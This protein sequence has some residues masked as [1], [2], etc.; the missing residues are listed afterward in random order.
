MINHWVLG[1]LGTQ[2]S[3]LR[4]SW[5]DDLSNPFSACVPC[6]FSMS[7]F[8]SWNKITSPSMTLQPAG[9]AGW[10]TCWGSVC[11]SSLPS[12]LWA[13]R[14]RHVFLHPFDLI[15]PWATLSR[16]FFEQSL[17]WGFCLMNTYSFISVFSET[18][19]L[20]RE[21][22]RRLDEQCYCTGTCVGQSPRVQ[23]TMARAQRR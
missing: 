13:N 8:F 14:S 10:A 6:E 4:R 19:F 2:N 7:S 15:L 23:N 9:V 11:L 3:N 20:F 21:M 17:F 12:C 16:K 18:W 1:T 22:H 5:E